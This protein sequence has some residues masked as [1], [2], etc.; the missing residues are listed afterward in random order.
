LPTRVV[1]YLIGW[2]HVIYPIAGCMPGSVV[3]TPTPE[4]QATARPVSTSTPE[5]TATPPATPIPTPTPIP[6]WDLRT[7]SPEQQGVDSDRLLALFDYV[8]REDVDVHSVLVVRNGYLVME[9]YFYPYRQR[10]LHPLYSC[11]KSFTGALVGIA[12]EEG[13]LDV[14][15]LVLDY[16]PDLVL[17]NDS[18]LKQEMTVAHLLTMR[19]GFDWPESSV[20]Y[21]SANNILRQLFES[22]EW[23]SFVLDRPMAAA[24]GATF[25]YNTGATHLLGAIL[26]QATGLPLEDYARERLFKPLRISALRWSTDPNGIAFGGGGLSLTPRDMAKFGYLYLAGGVWEG[27]QIVP[28]EW[29]ET[30]T[31]RPHY[32][33]LWWRL[34]NGGYAALG[35]KGQ[36]IV[37]IPDL[38]M[39]VV[40]TGDM[41][42]TTSGYLV[43]GLVIPAARSTAPLPENPEA[44]E[45]LNARI[46]A[47]MNHQNAP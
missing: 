32:G 30:S 36:R 47:T 33:Y 22:D 34:G 24:P 39:V 5:P 45:M 20:S 3:P 42:G 43:D 35:Y 27:E 23:I 28:A 26:E 6:F 31:T 14:D 38:D 25:N 9:A 40:V 16:F 13:Y 37:V 44:W 8:E 7:S 4:V 2:I 21:A 17:E 1:I 15:D 41:P 19:T 18:S 10:T 12:V 11:T 46:E 29:I